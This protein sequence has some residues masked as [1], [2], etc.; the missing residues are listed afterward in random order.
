MFN[1]GAA[2]S[3]AE[4]KQR[5]QLVIVGA[6]AGGLPLA[7]R[8][9]HHYRSHDDVSVALID[10]SSTH[11]WKPLLHEKAAGTLTS[12]EDEINLFAHGRRHGYRFVLGEL[13]AIDRDSKKVFLSAFQSEAGEEILPKR[14]ID[15][16][17]LTLAV[18]ATYNDFGTPGVAPHAFFLDDCAAANRLH[19]SFVHSLLRSNFYETTSDQQASKIVI[20]GAGATG[21]ELAAELKRVIDAE[22]ETGL[23]D[24]QD[25]ETQILL[26]EAADRCLPSVSQKLGE[27]VSRKLAQQGIEI[28]VGAAVKS[29][30]RGAVIVDN[31][32]IEARMV[33][34]TAGVK[35]HD[36]LSGLGLESDDNDTIV[37][38]ASLQTK[39][40]DSIFAMGDCASLSYS[41]DGDE[42]HVPA[43]AQASFQQANFLAREIPTYLQQGH[44]TRSFRFRNR[45]TLI[46]MAEKDATGQLPQPGGGNFGLSGTVALFAYHLLYRRH[47]LS[48][49]GVTQTL[50]AMLKDSLSLVPRVR[51]KLH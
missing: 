46:T 39:T 27:Q 13:Q 38:R 35:G 48:I 3:N 15:Y 37:V 4:T 17:V 21:V 34:W 41:E 50:V 7:T 10:K 24:Y 23:E 28:R 20:I 11:V 5:R 29:V 40:D 45:G 44:V 43:S 8:L 26:L 14:E 42:I 51:I 32:K 30:E 31:E 6:G 25:Q 22:T 12:N 49:L 2:R 47:Q 36:W 33:I 18:G 16:E 9:S 1:R 19:Q